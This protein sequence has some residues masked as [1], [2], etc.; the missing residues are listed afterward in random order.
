MSCTRKSYFLA[1]DSPLTDA[2]L[3][4]TLFKT[5]LLSR[6]N[7]SSSPHYCYYTYMSRNF[8]RGYITKYTIEKRSADVAKKFTSD[9]N[10]LDMITI[11]PLKLSS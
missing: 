10:S 8:P 1:Y 3:F 6:A 9:L 7:A 11:T 2:H 4:R 5:F